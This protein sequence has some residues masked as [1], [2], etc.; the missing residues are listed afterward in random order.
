MMDLKRFGEVVIF[1]I[2]LRKRSC[3]GAKMIFELI[4]LSG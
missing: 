3:D 4:E 1:S 2:W